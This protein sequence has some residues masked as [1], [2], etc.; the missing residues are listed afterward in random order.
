MKE[1]FFYRRELV[2]ET[3]PAKTS[4]DEGANSMQKPIRTRIDSNEIKLRRPNTSVQIQNLNTNVQRTNSTNKTRENALAT[5][6]C[7]I[8]QLKNDNNVPEEKKVDQS[9]INAT[10]NITSQSGLHRYNGNKNGDQSK[11]GKLSTLLKHVHPNYNNRGYNDDATS[12][13]SSDKE[14]NNN[15]KDTSNNVD[16]HQS[17][18]KDGF[19]N[20]RKPPYNHRATANKQG[21]SVSIVTTNEDLDFR[22]DMY[23]SKTNFKD[24]KIIVLLD[25][26]EYWVYKVEDTNARKDLMMK[27][28]EVA[29]NSPNVIQP[30]IGDVYGVLYETIWHRAMITSLYPVRVHFIDS[31]KDEM[32]EKCSEIRDIQDLVKVPRF[33]RKIRVQAMNAKGKNLLHGDIISVKML[34]MDA[35]KTIL[36]EV[37]EQSVNLAACTIKDSSQSRSNM[38]NAVAKAPQGS[39][40]LSSL[41]TEQT[42]TIQL[43]SIIDAFFNLL[44]EVSEL[45]ISGVI[46][47]SEC[48][49]KNVYSGTIAPDG[50][51]DNMNKI[52]NDLPMECEKM[53]ETAANYK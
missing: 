32:L 22:K 49:G 15:S 20:D 21:V 18:Q 42:P 43:L 46:Q 19:Q 41:N 36:V 52:T 37:E 14:I 13:T 11:N 26:N 4:K 28:Q 51:D 2:E 23:L 8:D 12:E 31:G 16:K 6:K 25:N 10:Y 39:P 48:M 38:N 5:N 30:M 50:F 44:D 1:Y 7:P 3:P 47:I 29:K 53:K 24:V 45:K 34:S 9:V 27:L 33:A 40:K 35:E 17:H